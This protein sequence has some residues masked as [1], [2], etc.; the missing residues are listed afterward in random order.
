MEMSV[1]LKECLEISGELRTFIQRMA[2]AAVI[3]IYELPEAKYRDYAQVQECPTGL[4]IALLDKHGFDENY[5]LTWEELDD[6]GF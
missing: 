1:T 5:Y 3:E 4:D 2:A 6:A